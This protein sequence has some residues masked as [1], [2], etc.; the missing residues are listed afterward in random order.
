MSNATANSKTV[1]MT[2]WD[3][4]LT[5]LKSWMFWGFVLGC[6]VTSALMTIIQNNKITAEIGNREKGFHVSI[7]ES[8]FTTD[9][10]QD[11]KSVYLSVDKVITKYGIPRHLFLLEKLQ[12]KKKNLTLEE[13]KTEVENTSFK[14]LLIKHDEIPKLKER[15]EAGEDISNEVFDLQQ[16]INKYIKNLKS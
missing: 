7:G 3:F 4:I 14:L 5:I 9:G 16:S 1:G 8:D 6:I 2:L 12:Q 13:K 15:C 11:L 10:C